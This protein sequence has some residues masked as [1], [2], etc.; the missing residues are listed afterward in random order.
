MRPERIRIPRGESAELVA[1]GLTTENCDLLVK[2]LAETRDPLL[3]AYRR[4]AL[5]DLGVALSSEYVPLGFIAPARVAA[6]HPAV[7]EDQI[8]WARGPV[9]LDLAGGWSDTPP[10]TNRYGGRVVNVSVDL[11]GQPPIQVFVRRLR[12]PA[13]RFT[14][15]DLGISQTVGTRAE[16]LAFH[17]PGTSFALPRA[18]L[19]LLGLADQHHANRALRETLEGIGCGIDISLLCAVPKGSGLGTSSILG[20]VILAGLHRFFGIAVPLDDLFMQVLALEQ[21]MT[22]GG[23]WQDQVGG[24]R[25]GVK[26]T[27]TRPGLRSRPVVRQLDPFL[28]EHHGCTER[29]TLFYTGFTRLAKNILQEVVD[30]VNRAVP[31]YLFTHD[32]LKALAGEAC[33]AFAFRNLDRLAT[34]IH[35]SLRQNS[36]VHRSTLN[37]D[38]NAMIERTRGLFQGMKLLGAGGGGFALFIS[39]D[40][41]QADDLR[42]VLRSQFENDRAR[43]VDFTLDKKGLEVTVS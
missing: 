40:R 14:S 9:R 37:A 11:N 22:T 23:G 33:D 1:L 17:D 13:I 29:M 39:K 19:V 34:V 3:A 30:G 4:Q 28:F 35:S 24:L 41:R 27:T 18:A 15:V 10:Y 20:G 36:L 12:E 8:V 16:L 32:C 26:D 2:Q 42:D 31:A 6:L 21:M 7:K 5:R 25:G 43:L 38:I